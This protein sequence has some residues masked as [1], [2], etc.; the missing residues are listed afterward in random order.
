MKN[1]EKLISLFGFGFLLII[2]VICYVFAL[3][4]AMLF[5]CIGKVKQ[6]WK[7]K[8]YDFKQTKFYK[9]FWR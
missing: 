2:L 3:L 6:A 5:E 9:E 4:M 7:F 1:L 8:V